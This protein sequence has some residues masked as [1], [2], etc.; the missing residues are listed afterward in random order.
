MQRSMRYVF[1]VGA[2]VVLLMLAVLA[3]SPTARRLAPT[4]LYYNLVGR[5]VAALPVGA[6]QHVYDQGR[7]FCSIGRDSECGGYRLVNARGLAVGAAARGQGTTAAWCVDYVV[8]RRNT[9]R[10]SGQLF[11]WSNIPRAMV[12]T[13]QGAGQYASF[14]V[15]RCDM[16]TL[17]P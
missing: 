17:E 11:Y 13:E 3:F 15:E 14:S 4:W 5:H 7:D 16:N 1:G 10:L 9:G 12:V 8:L 6:E 2:G